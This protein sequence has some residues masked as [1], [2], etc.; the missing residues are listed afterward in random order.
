M[1]PYTP[2]THRGRD[3]PGLVR[4]P[5]RHKEVGPLTLRI[6]ILG[7]ARITDMAVLKP[8]AALDVPI[9]SVAAR[10]VDRALA[11]AVKHRIPHVR[12]NYDAILEDPD[13][14]AVYIPLPASLH[15]RWTL[16]AINAGKHVLCEKPFTA[17]TAQAE[18]VADAAAA[19][20]DVVVMEAY[21]SGHHP[22]LSRLRE[23]LASGI[24]G[25]I[26]TAK[27]TFSVAI[28]PRK[29]IRWNADLGGGSLLDVGYYPVRLLRDLFGE[30]EVLQARANIRKDV[31]S[32][33]TAL[34][35]FSDGVRGEIVTS[36]WPPRPAM[37][38]LSI[39]GTAGQLRMRMP[40]HP[41]T[42]GRISVLTGLRR[43]VDKADR[44]RSGVVSNSM[45]WTER[46]DRISTYLAQL[47]DFRDAID[48]TGPNTTDAA[49]AVA[50]MRTIDDIYQA[51]G[52]TPRC[53]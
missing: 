51:A 23:I 52:M 17:N 20:S 3:E 18:V 36:M 27:A 50:Q 37:P 47:R 26:L 48:G 25:E 21:H 8:A 28:P 29:D 14:T 5:K 43:P 11:Y 53:P 19:N 33:L 41:Q 9:H 16:A 44:I 32:S 46:A 15:A 49:A 34:L 13:V 24:L 38:S 39:V 1:T 10:D 4:S 45:R 22:S 7:A 40:Y 6:G 2:T 42:A 12:D 31:D 30:A 35:Q